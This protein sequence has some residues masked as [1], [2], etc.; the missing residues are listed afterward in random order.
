M[1]IN[2]ATD[3]RSMMR[4]T[5]KYSLRAPPG[6]EEEEKEESNSCSRKPDPQSVQASYQK[7][8]QRASSQPSRNP[9]SRMRHFPSKSG[10]AGGRFCRFCLGESRGGPD[11]E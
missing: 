11:N 7:P 10:G 9:M 4:N 1:G 8:L 5:I 2:A 6:L 3:D